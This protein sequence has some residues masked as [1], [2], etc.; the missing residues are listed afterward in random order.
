[1][2]LHQVI[3]LLTNAVQNQFLKFNAITSKKK[4]KKKKKKKPQ[5]LVTGRAN[6]PI[7]QVLFGQQTDKFIDLRCMYM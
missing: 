2:I 7:N 3:H 6:K 5:N 1:M 4:K